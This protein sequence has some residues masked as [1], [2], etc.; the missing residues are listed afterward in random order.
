M[1]NIVLSASLEVCREHSSNYLPAATAIQLALQAHLLFLNTGA[2]I[3]S[4][5]PD[6]TPRMEC[7]LGHG[8]V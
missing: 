6:N 4:V 8:S 7:N 3:G 5:S 1:A 2:V